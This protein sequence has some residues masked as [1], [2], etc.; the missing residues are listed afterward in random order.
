MSSRSDTREAGMTDIVRVG[1]VGDRDPNKP[2][3]PATDE[4]LEHAA[5]ALGVRV[6]AE[7]LP[8]EALVG[9]ADGVLAGFDAILCAPGSPYGSL[10]GA[11]EA[12]RLARE[13]GIP[14][15]GT[16]GGFQHV[17][18]EYAR[19]V[20]GFADAHHAEYDPSAFEPF[21][22]ALSCS[23]FG[24]RM[25]VAFEPGSNVRTFY[26]SGEAE[27][28]YRCN[29]GLAPDRRRLVERGGLRA[30][31]VDGD[32]EARVLELPDHPFYV[33]T[34]FVPQMTS[35]RENPHPLIVSLLRA[36]IDSRERANA[37]RSAVETSR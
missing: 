19:N 8:T 7:W 4:A 11:L 9:R 25:K 29:Y 3:H 13:G 21:I 34:L 5:G 31:G 30:V 33:A 24:L 18:L 1:I 10:E 14:L 27:E 32:G 16:C 28:E 37:S 35:S 6:E 15:I 26:G 12:I 20:L 36:A 23:P 17:V 2:T 22:S